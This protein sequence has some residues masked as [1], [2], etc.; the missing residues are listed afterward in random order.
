M[1]YPNAHGLII[2]L[3]AS[4]MD[5][6]C[7]KPEAHLLIEKFLSLKKENSRNLFIA[8]VKDCTENRRKVISIFPI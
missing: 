4:V 2:N 1:Q 3:P 5:S 6:S 8:N 7:F